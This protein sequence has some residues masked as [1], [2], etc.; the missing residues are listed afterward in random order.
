[1]CGTLHPATSQWV[2]WIRMYS[3][4]FA[5]SWDVF[6]SRR[7]FTTACISRTLSAKWR[8]WSLV[9]TLWMQAGA[10]NLMQDRDKI[11]KRWIIDQGSEMAVNV[12]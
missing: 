7:L 10:H 9:H 8:S 2:Q 4:T 5:L 12:H 3:F 6:P 11:T 1:M